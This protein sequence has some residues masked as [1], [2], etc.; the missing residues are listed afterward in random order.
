MFFLEKRFMR[1]HVSNSHAQSLGTSPQ[2]LGDSRASAC[3]ATLARIASACM[4]TTLSHHG[5]EDGHERS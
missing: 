4:V 2:N 1:V 5:G 3:L